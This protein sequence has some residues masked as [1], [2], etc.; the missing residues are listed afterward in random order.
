MYNTADLKILTRF[1]N[2]ETKQQQQNIYNSNDFDNNGM[3]YKNF[4]KL[5]YNICDIITNVDIEGLYLY[6][7]I[8]CHPHTQNKIFLNCT[9]KEL[10]DK[11][12]FKDIRTIKKYLIKLINKNV[13]YIDIGSQNNILDIKQND[14]LN[15]IILYNNQIIINNLLSNERIKNINNMIIDSDI[16]N[17]TLSDIMIGYKPIP[18]EYFN[19]CLIHLTALQCCITIYLIDRFK[20]F[21]CYNY[22]SND[23]PDN[24]IYKYMDCEYAFPSLENIANVLKSDRGTIKRN[25][26]IL[27]DKGI[28]SYTISTDKPFWSMTKQG[29]KL[30]NPNYRYRVKLLQ[31]IEYNYYLIYSFDRFDKRTQQEKDYVRNNIISLLTSKEYKRVKSIDWIITKYQKNYLNYFEK[32]LINGI[33]F[34]STKKDVCLF[35]NFNNKSFCSNDD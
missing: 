26:D 16:E 4:F 15:I 12:S 22:P 35:E 17:E 3:N 1:F 14:E 9:I 19:R 31:R 5:N 29:Y 23:N 24:I 27:A 13:L 18:I 7:T 30:K 11:T 25:I 6:L 2:Y 28:L 21:D 34:Y 10:C 33:D 20:L 8:L 32:D